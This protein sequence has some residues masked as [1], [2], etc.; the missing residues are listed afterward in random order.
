[1]NSRYQTVAH[2]EL[3]GNQGIMSESETQ[4]YPLGRLLHLDDGRKF[5][6]ARAGAVALDPGKM[7]GSP[8]AASER[9]D[10]VNG[11]VAIAANAITFT[12]TAV[13]TIT[14]NQ[15]KDGWACMVDDTGEGIQYKIKG[16]TAATAGNESTVELYDPIVTAT[17]TTTSCILVAS[18]WT[19][20]ILTPDDVIKATGVPTRAITANYYY[21]T[22][23]GGLAT[24]L[25]GSSTG[26]ATDERNLR[27]DVAAAVDGALDSAAVTTAGVEIVGH[28][29][30]DS[31]DCVDTEYWPVWLTID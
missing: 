10:T 18:P 9:D 13:G 27:V 26:V 1:M 28:H 20:L 15:F 16:N 31:T 29:V 7:T 23:T 4:Q 3:P 6:Y 25:M 11:A 22:Q 30:F 2:T 8:L 24:C 19:G 17:G 14:L 12:Q 5:R 21:W